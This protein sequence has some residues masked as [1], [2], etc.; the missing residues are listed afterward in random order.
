MRR[1]GRIYAS[2]VLRPLAEQLVAEL[3]VRLESRIVDVMCDGGTASTEVRRQCAGAG[4]IL[5][6]TTREALAD[7][8]AAVDA[9]G[10]VEA[11]LTNGSTLPLAD[12]TCDA[13]MSLLTLGFGEPQALY[14]EMRRV[15]HRGGRIV[16]L[17]WAAEPPAHERILI[18]AYQDAVGSPPAYA[19]AFQ[20]TPQFGEG[21]AVRDVVRFDGAHQ[22]WDAVLS[23]RGLNGHP[24]LHEIRAR[25]GELLGEYTA[26]DGTIRIPIELTMVAQDV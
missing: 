7:A 11:L 3:D 23:H 26:A 9:G 12:A 20:S 13:A 18:D 2:A 21:R 8:I 24:S 22:Y 6:D 19:A 16:S 15:V 25:G 1:F 5:V 14:S 10:S 4:I 17:S